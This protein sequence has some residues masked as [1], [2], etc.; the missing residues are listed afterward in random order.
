MNWIDRWFNR[1]HCPH[2]DVRGI[3]G[4]E[5]NHTPGNFRMQCR[6]CGRYLDGP[7]SIS[8]ERGDDYREIRP[9]FVPKEPPK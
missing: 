8:V 6:G 2:V 7:V 1:R 5:I 4:D 3:Y 9:P